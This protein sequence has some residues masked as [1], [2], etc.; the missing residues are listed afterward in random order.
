MDDEAPRSGSTTWNGDVA[1]VLILC[2]SGEYGGCGGWCNSDG[3]D[4]ICVC[5]D[6]PCVCALVSC[7]LRLLWFFSR[8]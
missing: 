2:H 4:V 3:L 5:G 8:A 6:F 7:C 1:G